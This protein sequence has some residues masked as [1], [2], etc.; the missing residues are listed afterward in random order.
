[1]EVPA[2]Q[3]S[4]ALAPAH[5]SQPVAARK[6]SAPS[7][8]ASVREQPALALRFHSASLGLPAVLVLALLLAP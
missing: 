2:F 8:A 7:A 1:V 5:T 4:A 6:V 3:P